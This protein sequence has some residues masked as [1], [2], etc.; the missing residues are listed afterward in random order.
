VELESN[1]LEEVD[2]GLILDPEE[3]Y[4]EYVDP[5]HDPEW[6]AL[7]TKLKAIPRSW[8]MQ[9]TGL[10]RSTI[11]A[12]RNGHAHPNPQTRKKLQRA[13]AFDAMA[14]RLYEPYRLMSMRT[15]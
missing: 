11:T 13:T 2:A 14:Q 6:E 8:L 7:I 12:L 4:T 9:E 10:A 3:L 5:Q 15:S 1:R